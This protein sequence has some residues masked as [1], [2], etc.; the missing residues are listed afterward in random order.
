MEQSIGRAAD[1]LLSWVVP[2]TTATACQ[3][4]EWNCTDIYCGGA[5]DRSYYLRIFY[6]C[7]CRVT[8]TKCNC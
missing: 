2:S 4:N 7:S 8:A 5:E 6:G 1:W 3:C